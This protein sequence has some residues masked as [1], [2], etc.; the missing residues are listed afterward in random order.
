[1]AHDLR[2][3]LGNVLSYADLL[4]DEC[5]A[6]ARP[7]QAEQLRRIRE[8]GFFMFELIAD[9]L[10]TQRIDCG[11]L[12]VVPSS[13]DL[14]ELVRAAAERARFA[15]A[16]KNIRLD[17][18]L[19]PAALSAV[20]DPRKI[21]RVLDNLTSNAVK[22]SPTG[23]PAEVGDRDLE[24]GVEV[25]FRDH[26]PGIAPGERERRFKNFSRTSARPTRGEKSTGLG[27][28][29]VKELLKIHGGTIH[30]DSEPG[31]GATFSVAL[32]GARGLSGAHPA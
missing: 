25:W 10:D 9:V 20:V 17:L 27:L 3:P 32:P 29:I 1:M 21:A 6:A 13:E 4:L 11:K 26:G 19:P 28:F 5:D 31:A 30:V 12:R 24:R 7:E 22:F 14:C 16:Q 18:D 8:N 23:T 2:N 15:A